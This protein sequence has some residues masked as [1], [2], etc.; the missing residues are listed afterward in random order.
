MS[1]PSPKPGAARG[2][3]LPFPG[4]HHTHVLISAPGGL[5][6]KA[7]T[8]V[9]QSRDERPVQGRSG[10]VSRV[11]AGGVALAARHP[12]W[13]LALRAG[14]ALGTFIL[15]DSFLRRAGDL[16]AESYARSSLVAGLVDHLGLPL[17]V[18]LIAAAAG[19]LRWGRLGDRWDQIDQGPTLRVFV[20]L[21]AALMAWAFTT[22]EFNYYFGQGYDRDRLLILV[23]LLLLWFRPFFIYPFLLLT[24]A[25]MFQLGE[26]PLSGGAFFAHSLQILHVLG[27]FGAVFLLHA[28]TGSRKTDMFFFLTCC[29]VAGAYWVPG[30]GKLRLGWILHGDLH[31]MPLAAYA[32]GWLSFLE[33][34]TV[35]RLGRGLAWVD[36]P[37]R[38]FV[39]V[40]ELGCLV[41]LWRRAISA[42]LLAGVI[43]F[44]L[45]TFALYG[46]LFWAWLVLDSGL[47]V[48]LLRDRKGDTL[49]LYGR[50]QLVVSVL[51]IASASYWVHPARLAWFDTRLSYTYRFQVIG[52]SG[53]QYTLPPRFFE[54][55]GDTFT[56]S[57]FGY[58]SPNHR[59]L[60]YPYATT[61]DRTLAA[62]LRST[63]TA[64]GV[65]A[66]EEEIGGDWYDE[67]RAEQ[68]YDFLTRYITHW[69][70]GKHGGLDLHRW[71]SPPHFW[72]FPRGNAFEGQEK[73][74]ELVVTEVTTLFD[75]QRLEVIR[76]QEL[77][78]IRLRRP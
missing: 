73:I 18:L 5:V 12:H 37:L 6:S 36:W 3:V 10:V 44:H 19:L 20:T 55:Y 4:S 14:V 26:P 51:L 61:S 64:A 45:G 8:G 52:V 39:F 67:R 78:R 42:F 17:V 30:L 21:L 63:T 60:V 25:V 48:L 31:L 1:G 53:T 2:F 76:D 35:V 70:A 40:V 62:R 11:R 24:F 75:G 32:H 71:R 22:L 72:S 29:L 38:L 65:F 33:P 9:G 57:N 27:L 46:Y 28:L 56:M 41:F 34:A 43:L 58:L 68:L 66:L 54:P 23:L 50:T 15:V 74:S 16:P 7:D 47:L 49:N 77:R 69:N 59:M 13:L